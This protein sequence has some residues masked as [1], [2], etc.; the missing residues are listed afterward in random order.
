MS[1]QAHAGADVD[2]G[3]DH[4]LVVDDAAGVEDGVIAD[5]A[6]GADQGPGGDDHAA[7]DG[8]ICR[9]LGRGVDDGGQVEAGGFDGL[10][11]H[12]AHA[13]VADG[14]DCGGASVDRRG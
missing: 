14:D 12:A 7:A 13:V 9:D 8:D 6:V 10:G 4:G 1:G 3:A 2:A 11:D 5:L